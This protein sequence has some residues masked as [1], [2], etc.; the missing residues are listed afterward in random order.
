MSR[1]KGGPGSPPTLTARPQAGQGQAHTTDHQP[2]FRL[3]S[4]ACMGPMP[5]T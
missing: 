3:G 2:R 1:A 4:E 5:Y